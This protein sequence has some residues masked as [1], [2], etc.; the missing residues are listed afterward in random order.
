MSPVLLACLIKLVFVGHVPDYLD[1]EFLHL[2]STA[3]MDA[4]VIEEKI[5]LVVIAS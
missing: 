4:T 5:E 2:F 1:V 3:S